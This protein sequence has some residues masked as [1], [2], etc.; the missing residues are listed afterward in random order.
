MSKIFIVFEEHNSA[1]HML[2]LMI[3]ISYV[4]KQDKLIKQTYLILGQ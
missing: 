3:R 1:I 2:E 4:R